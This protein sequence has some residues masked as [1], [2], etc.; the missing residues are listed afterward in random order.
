VSWASDLSALRAGSLSFD[1]FAT[2][3]GSRFKRWAWH[4][5]ERWPLRCLDPDDLAQEGMIEAWQAVDRFDPARGVS[6]VSFVE[7]RVGERMQREISRA[8]GW[9]RKDRGN[10][11]PLMLG[12]DDVGIKDTNHRGETYIEV[13]EAGPD[14]EIRPDVRIDR[15]RGIS[16]LFSDDRLAAFSVLGASLGVDTRIIGLKLFEDENTR[17]EFGFV[18]RN[19]A[20]REVRKKIRK[21]GRKLDHSVR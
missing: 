10:K 19:H 21:A 14:P 13:V 12:I 9:P 16:R 17:D 5:Y 18:D 15:D 1:E 6:L 11:I 2:L 3:H 4:F 8:N 7:Y 20:A